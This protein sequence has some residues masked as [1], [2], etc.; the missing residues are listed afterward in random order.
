[1]QCLLSTLLI[2]L[3]SDNLIGTLVCGQGRAAVEEGVPLEQDRLLEEVLTDTSPGRMLHCPPSS[4]S[5]KQKA[6]PSSA[7]VLPTLGKDRCIV[8]PRIEV[9]LA[10]LPIGGKGVVERRVGKGTGGLVGRGVGRVAGNVAGTCLGGGPSG[11]AGRGVGGGAWD[12]PG[13]DLAGGRAAATLLTLGTVSTSSPP[14][15]RRLAAALDRATVPEATY[16]NPCKRE[17]VSFLKLM[18]QSFES[19]IK[20]LTCFPLSL[21]LCLV[22]IFKPSCCKWRK[23]RPN[24]LS[25]QPCRAPLE[26][27]PSS[28]TLECLLH[29]WKTSVY[30][31]GSLVWQGQQRGRCT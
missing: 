22:S 3:V 16:M 23:V 19:N 31:V 26:I 28:S 1:L 10:D 7:D 15:P 21:A 5:E 12:V 25:S 13:S 24:F 27:H 2:Y 14:L 29:G 17:P 4:R 8:D 20:C 30:N 11:I 18:L 6:S 9:P